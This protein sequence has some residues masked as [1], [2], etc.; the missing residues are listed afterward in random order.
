MTK[1]FF[2]FQNVEAE[3]STNCGK[4]LLKNI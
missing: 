4:E 3:I 2:D 1:V